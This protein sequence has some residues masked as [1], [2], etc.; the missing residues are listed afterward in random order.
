MPLWDDVLQ[1]KA[2]RVSFQVAVYTHAFNPSGLTAGQVMGCGRFRGADTL[3][4]TTTH[5]D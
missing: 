1:E 5:G 2:P 4:D 3:T